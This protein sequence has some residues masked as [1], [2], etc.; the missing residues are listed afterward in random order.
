LYNKNAASFDA[1]TATELAQ[2]WKESG[3]K[4]GSAEKREKDLKAAT[5]E[6]GASSGGSRKKMYTRASIRELMRTDPS[7]YKA[8]RDEIEAAYRE[9]RVKA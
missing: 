3:P 8:Q 7:G 1:T 9:G 4:P 6:K 2:A 5:M